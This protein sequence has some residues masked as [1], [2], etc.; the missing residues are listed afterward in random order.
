VCGS[1]TIHG[2]D[3]INPEHGG[4][5]G[6]STD[7]NSFRRFHRPTNL[8]LWGRNVILDAVSAVARV[9]LVHREVVPTRHDPNAGLVQLILGDALRSK[10][11]HDILR[12]IVASFWHLD[13][14]PGVD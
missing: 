6:R 4:S 9:P 12:G 1:N 11:S 13:V 3:E 14:K 10:G 5:C 8:V 2:K 7:R